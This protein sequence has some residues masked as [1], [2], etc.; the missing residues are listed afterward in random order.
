MLLVHAVRGT[1]VYFEVE[2][3]PEKYWLADLKVGESV[4]SRFDPV[5]LDVGAGCSHQGNQEIHG[6]R[7]VELR[8]TL[9]PVV[10]DLDIGW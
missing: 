10:G 5:S 7:Q 1:L 6:E 4:F 3:E 9:L 8:P 2:C